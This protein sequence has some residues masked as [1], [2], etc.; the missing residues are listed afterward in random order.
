MEDFNRCS[1]N[2][3]L[4]TYNDGYNN[5]K[6][7]VAC[8]TVIQGSPGAQSMKDSE[9]CSSSPPIKPC[10]GFDSKIRTTSLRLPIPKFDL[11]FCH[12]SSLVIMELLSRSVCRMFIKGRHNR[13]RIDGLTPFS[14]SDPRIQ[15]CF[16]LAAFVE[17][18]HSVTWHPP[19][20]FG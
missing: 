6:V 16:F 12:R 7:S 15:S 2:E 20:F 11:Q 9:G 18:E 14:V 3:A 4:G 5:R 1:G 19:L 13:D 8:C 10:T 17:F